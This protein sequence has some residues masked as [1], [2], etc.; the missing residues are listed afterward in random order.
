MAI[1]T[2]GDL[3]RLD[4]FMALSN[5]VKLVRGARHA[6]TIAEREAIADDV[7]RR[8]ARKPGGSMEAERGAAATGA[9]DRP[10]LARGL[11]QGAGVTAPRCAGPGG[12][13][14]VAAIGSVQQ[15]AG[16]NER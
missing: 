12:E 3:L 4:L 7:V 6:M 1:K 2:R 14:G 16:D 15:A 8:V 5:A 11:E 10:R 9:S 13:L